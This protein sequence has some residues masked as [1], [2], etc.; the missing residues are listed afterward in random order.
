MKFFVVLKI[1]EFTGHAKKDRIEL[2]S[3]PTTEFPRKFFDRLLRLVRFEV[4]L[5][6]IK[7]SHL[8]RGSIFVLK[9][10]NFVYD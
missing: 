6:L 2:L 5:S 4:V 3:E 1:I 10:S 9:I 7:P 8:F